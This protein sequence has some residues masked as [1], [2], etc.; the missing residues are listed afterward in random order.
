M[1]HEHNFHP[2]NRCFHKFRAG[3]GRGGEGR[4]GQGRA[5]Q[6]RTG[7]GRARQGRAGE[8]RGGQVVDTPFA[9]NHEP[10]EYDGRSA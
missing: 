7:Q 5:G 3:Q 1:C 6:G 2:V 4:A 9:N 10:A 8:G